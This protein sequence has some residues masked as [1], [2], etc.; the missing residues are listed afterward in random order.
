[1]LQNTILQNVNIFRNLNKVTIL[2]KVTTWEKFLNLKYKLEKEQLSR[3]RENNSANSSSSSN[4]PHLDYTMNN[5]TKFQETRVFIT[6]CHKLRSSLLKV[7]LG[8]T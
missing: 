4:F 8:K 7:S 6:S 3:V 2:A 5:T 1:M